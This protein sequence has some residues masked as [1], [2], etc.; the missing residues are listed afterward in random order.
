[1]YEFTFQFYH[2]FFHRRWGLLAGSGAVITSAKDMTKWMNFHLSGGQNEEGVEIMQ[3]EHLKEVHAPR[4]RIDPTSDK[5]TRKPTFPVTA[6][7][8]IY[9]HGLRRGFYRGGF[10]S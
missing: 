7:S 9:A 1:M 2:P 10:N 4:F 8:D 6:S 3:N 5:D